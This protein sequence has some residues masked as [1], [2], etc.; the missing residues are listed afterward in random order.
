MK[1]FFMC[2]SI[3]VCCTCFAQTQTENYSFFKLYITNSDNHV[4]LVKWG[5]YWELPGKKYTD[6]LSI[7]K[8][9][10]HIEKLMG[11]N[12]A[13][14]LKLR[15]LFTLYSEKRPNPTIMHYYSLKSNETK[16][17][18]LPSCTE[19]KWFNLEDALKE[20]P[21]EDMKEILKMITK[22]EDSVFGGSI[23][24]IYNLGED[25]KYS[26]KFLEPLYLLSN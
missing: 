15:G 24:R 8:T 9:I 1:N 13:T 11:I 4:L 23:M 2:I 5:K 25:D 12:D 14:N 6:T 18:P 17:I 19:I 21:Y 16:L 22:N 10:N 20:I 3:L 26:I 7:N